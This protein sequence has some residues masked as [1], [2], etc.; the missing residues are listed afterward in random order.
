MSKIESSSEFNILD[1]IG[2]V[3]IFMQIIGLFYFSQ[4]AA[5]FRELYNELGGT[6][7]MLTTLVLKPW[8]SISLGIVSL[9]I[10]SLQWHKSIKVSLKKRRAVVV[11]SFIFVTTVITVCI[12]AIY[13]PIIKLASPIS[14]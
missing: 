3:Y 10:F 9:I 8:F 6:Q 7:P 13:M 5:R 14:S 4:T 1:W 12:I 11:F 2:V